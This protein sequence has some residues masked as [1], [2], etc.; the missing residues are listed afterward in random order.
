MSCLPFPSRILCENVWRK[1]ARRF[2]WVR[3]RFEAFLKSPDI[4]RDRNLSAFFKSGKS[5]CEHWPVFASHFG[6]LLCMERTVQQRSLCAQ[7][8]ATWCWN[9]LRRLHCIS[10]R[11]FLVQAWPSFALRLWNKP[12]SPFLLLVQEVLGPIHLNCKPFL[13]QCTQGTPL[14]RIHAFIASDA[15]DSRTLSVKERKSL[16]SC[17]LVLVNGREAI[18]KA[19][20][21]CFV[22][23]SFLHWTDIFL[24]LPMCWH[25]PC[26]GHTAVDKSHWAPVHL[27]G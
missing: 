23:Y 5:S 3:S 13:M 21:G 16:V 7:P 4:L 8:G 24:A 26:I 1:G 11:N 20:W 15:A 18:S 17:H 19:D 10:S 14:K 2:H 27:A 9:D 22:F 25:C 12:V 6:L